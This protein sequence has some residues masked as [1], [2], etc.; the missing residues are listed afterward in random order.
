MKK[1]A[2]PK[3][4]EVTLKLVSYQ[5]FSRALKNIETFDI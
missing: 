2:S 3:I 1:D 5:D 4:I